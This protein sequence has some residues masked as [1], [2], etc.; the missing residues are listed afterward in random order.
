MLSDEVAMEAIKRRIIATGVSLIV[1]NMV[2]FVIGR[3]FKRFWPIP[4]VDG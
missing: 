2:G 4:E 1:C 3:A